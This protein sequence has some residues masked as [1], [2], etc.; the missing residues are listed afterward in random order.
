MRTINPR[1]WTP[2]GG[3]RMPEGMGGERRR[4]RGGERTE[5]AC[6]SQTRA[7][8]LHIRR[9]FLHQ[10]FCEH[11]RSRV[12]LEY[13]RLEATILQVCG[14]RRAK[15]EMYLLSNN[16]A[17]LHNLTQGAFCFYARERRYARP[18]KSDFAIVRE[19]D[20]LTIQRVTFLCSHHLP[21]AL[22]L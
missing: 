8:S 18:M 2:C 6:P 11:G 5:N 15:W 21:E 13:A 17:L 16:R 7:L 3:P 10:A 19:H 20:Q 22:P 1:G 9:L 14:C 12:G 4:K